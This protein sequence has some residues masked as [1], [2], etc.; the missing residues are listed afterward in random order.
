ML[1]QRV[2]GQTLAKD[3]TEER[4]LEAWASHR[5]RL[6]QGA[7]ENQMDEEVL[8]RLVGVQQEGVCASQGKPVVGAPET[9]HHRK[10]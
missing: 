8:G 2:Q 5:V 1:M 7:N 6:E 3:A 4:L 9:E 10:A